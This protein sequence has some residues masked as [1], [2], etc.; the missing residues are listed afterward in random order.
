MGQ[1]E[2]QVATQNQALTTKKLPKIE[3]LYKDPVQLAKMNELNML[4]NAPPSEDWIL[5]HPTAKKKVIN[6][7]G[8]EVNVPIDYIPIEIIEYLTTSIFVKTR[9]EVKHVQMIANSVQVTVRVHFLDP[10]TGEWDWEDGVGA[11]PLRTKHGATASDF[12]ALQDSAVQTGVPAAKTYAEKDAW[13]K[14]GKLFGRD[15]NRSDQELDYERWGDRFQI[16]D[17]P[18]EIRDQIAKET[19]TDKLGDI[20]QNNPELRANPAFMTLLNNRRLEIAT[21]A[22]NQ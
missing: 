18:Q 1:D 17:I 8:Q 22:Q 20:W 14:K 3:E 11:A 16:V 10:I 9:T 5:K 7:K 21:K 4:L 12:S 19:D 13:G 15:L 6:E 2:K